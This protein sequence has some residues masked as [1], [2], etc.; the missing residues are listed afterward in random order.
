MSRRDLHLFEGFGVELEYLIVDS[1]S[2]AVKPI[3]DQLLKAVAG[4]TV[5][6]VDLPGGVT[7][8]NELVLHVVELKGTEPLS[9]LDGAAVRFQENVRHINELLAP[10]GARLMP[11]GM[12]PWMD[13]QREMVLWPHEY[14][15]V[16]ETFHRIFDCRGHGW[17]NLQ[18]VHLNLPFQGDEEFGPLHAAIRVLLPLLPA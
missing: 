17:A 5:G 10:M 8:S 7:W 6:S 4:E 18:S 3:C 9:R 13:P 14:H 16:Y 11:S 12:H 1:E 2:L 15:A